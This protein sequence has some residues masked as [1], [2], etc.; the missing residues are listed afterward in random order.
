M[1][2]LRSHKKSFEMYSADILPASGKNVVGARDFDLNLNNSNL[3]RFST[4]EMYL[5]PKTVYTLGIGIS[6]VTCRS[7]LQH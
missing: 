7:D 4:C 6:I 3:A 1:P 5:M 2:A